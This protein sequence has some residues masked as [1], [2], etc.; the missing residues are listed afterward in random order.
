MDWNFF[1]DMMRP[2]NFPPHFIKIVMVC[3]SSTQYSLLV[4]G[5]PSEIFKPR[6]GL[7][8]GD[9]L[10]PLLFVLGMEYFSRTLM[11][12]GGNNQFKFHPRCKNLKLNHLCF[13]DDLMLFCRGEAKSVAILCECLE[14]HV[15]S[16]GLSSN[17]SMS[18]IYLAGIPDL[19]KD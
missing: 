3:I 17:A 19:V 8:Q 10:S 13:V 6:R 1:H 11:V 14:V 15:A 16:F 5:C 18:A 2:L 12:A 9:P 7:R 4:N